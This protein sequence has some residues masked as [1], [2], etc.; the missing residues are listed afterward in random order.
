MPA[1]TEKN[2]VNKKPADNTGITFPIYMDYQA[3]TPVDPRVWDVM[4][5][6]FRSK[7][8][9]PHSVDHA[10]GWEA[11]EAVAIAREQ[12]AALIDASPK[13]IIFTSGA[14]ESNNLAI[15]GL[16]RFHVQN[17]GKKRH[18]ITLATEHKCVL[19]TCESLMQEGFDVSFLN[20]QPDG[21]LDMAA[22]RSALREDTLLVSVMAVNNEI[23]VIQPLAEIGAL[24]RGHNVHFHTDAAQGFGKIPLDVDAMGIDLMSIS[25]HKIYGPKGIGALYVRRHPRVRLEPLFSGG[26]QER[27]VR[28]GTL[29][30]PLIAGLGKAAEIA[31]QGMQEENQ[32][33][34]VLR[35]RFMEALKPLAGHFRINGNM[36]KR[37]P[38][39]ISLSFP[40][41]PED[42][43]I[44]A[45]RGLAV[46]TGSACN[47]GSAAPSYV[48][49]ALGLTAG[50]AKTTIRLGFGR[51][52]TEAEMIYAATLLRQKLRELTAL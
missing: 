14:T 39:N 7:F 21:L 6:Y 24:C 43:M 46:S 45:L 38:G 35:D 51:F 40:G 44:L 12:M 37:I 47:S 15:K 41:V 18:V 50:E 10:Y 2:P 27:G 13:E 26:G 16:A 48:L 3:T 33:L 1:D 34:A 4:E 25:G 42:K 5:P 22:L 19:A 30:A 9:N 52:T 17:G 31:G 28:P 20:V 29:P 8:G 36:E 49:Q 32:R 11:E 23:G